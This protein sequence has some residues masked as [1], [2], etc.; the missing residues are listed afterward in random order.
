M[1]GAF[2]AHD[3]ERAG[4]LVPALP[5]VG[6]IAESTKNVP[7]SPCELVVTTSA[8]PS[9]AANEKRCGEETARAAAAD[10]LFVVE[11]RATALVGAGPLPLRPRVKPGRVGDSF[12]AEAEFV[13]PRPGTKFCRALT[14]TI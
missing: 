2:V 12:V 9:F 11:M 7:P 13:P 1:T 8:A 4:P 3:G 5:G 6:T 10:G 14:L